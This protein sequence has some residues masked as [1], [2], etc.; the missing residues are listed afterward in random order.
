MHM[1]VWEFYNVDDANCHVASM[2]DSGGSMCCLARLFF[3]TPVQS[4]FEEEFDE[5]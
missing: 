4:N 2:V 5:V 3:L 1:E